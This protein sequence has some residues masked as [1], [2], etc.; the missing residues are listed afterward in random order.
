[1]RK[2]IDTSASKL[3]AGMKTRAVL[4]PLYDDPVNSASDAL[5]DYECDSKAG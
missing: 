5:N 1:M 2:A 3:K 4:D